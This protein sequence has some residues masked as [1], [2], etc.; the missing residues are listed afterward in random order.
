[1]PEYVFCVNCKFYKEPLGNNAPRCLHP[2]AV[3]HDSVNLVTGRRWKTYQTCG[4]MRYNGELC[5]AHGKLFEL[6]HVPG[7]DTDGGFSAKV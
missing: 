3:S 6:S 4:S 5:G 1:M 2:K 7:G